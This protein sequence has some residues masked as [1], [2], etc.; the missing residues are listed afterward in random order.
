MNLIKVLVLNVTLAVACSAQAIGTTGVSG[1][2]N[3]HH[4]VELEDSSWG[5]AEAAAVSLG[6]H[7]VS[8]NGQSEN[9]FV[10]QVF[11]SGTWIG[12]MRIAD[13]GDTFVWSSGDALGYTNWSSFEPNN[14]GGH[15]NAVELYSD[16]TWNDLGAE[17]LRR[18]IVEISPVPE[19]SVG[20]MLV[21][22]LGI[23]GAMARRRQ[24]AA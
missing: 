24:K 22:G 18:G 14:S 15:E 16:G 9:E 1:D 6:G 7:L 3:G 23:V 21:A 4:Y 17:Q 19:P 5:D 13:G 10:R 8:I 2:F 12:L 11:G 20:I